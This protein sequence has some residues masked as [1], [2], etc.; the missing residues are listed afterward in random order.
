MK[1]KTFPILLGLSLAPCLHAQITYVDATTANTTRWDGV[2]FAPAADGVTGIDNNWEQRALGNSN[3]IYESNGENGAIENAPMLVT[4]ITGLQPGKEYSL[5]AYYWG[6]L[7]NGASNWRLKAAA[8]TSAIQDNGT[9]ANL[10]DDFLAT[11]PATH[12]AALNNAGGTAT[13]GTLASASTYV[14]AP[15]FIQADRTMM[16]ASLGSAVADGTGTL[17]IYIDDFESGNQPNRTW[18]DGF[19]YQILDSDNDGLPNSWEIANG[20]DPDVNDANEDPDLDDLTNIEEFQNN[21]L[22]L[23]PDTDGDG[24]DDGPEVDAGTLVNNEDSDGDFYLDGIETDR[25][26]D[27]LDINSIPSPTGGLKVDFSSQNSNGQAGVFHHEDWFTYVAPH[28]VDGITDRTE[29]WSVP[30][31]ASA[32]VSLAVAYPDTVANTVKQMIGRSNAQAAAYPGES[33][34]LVRDW[35]GIDARAASGGNGTTSDTTMTFT[36]QGLPAGTYRYRAYHHDVEFQAGRF[37]IKVTDSTRSAADLG[38]FRMSHTGMNTYHLSENPGGDP[39]ELSSTIDLIFVSN[40]TDP[41]VLTYTGRET[42]SVFTSFVVVN[43]L[44]VVSDADSDGD[45]VPNSVDLHPGTNDGTLDDDSDG[46][47]NLREYHLGTNPTLADTDGD[48]LN[49]GIETDSGTV[50]GSAD[51]GTSPFRADTDGDGANDG[52]E[53]A[54]ASNPFDP[55]VLPPTVPFKVL[56]ATLNPAT[57]EYTIQWT[58]TAGATYDIVYSDTLTDLPASWPVA[59]DNVASQGATTTHTIPLG[60]P[61]PARRFFVVIQN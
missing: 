42:A 36:F 10:A 41:V 35:I 9:P 25:Q 14:T 43:G 22:P 39:A 57:N 16:Q 61:R 28:E 6:T 54:A 52:A 23:N 13:V 55:T 31:F 45:F 4:T 17:K 24:L 3:T 46:L 40:G 20:T 11:D 44:E 53:I 7:A 26:T 34:R 37:G 1:P 33:P 51:S 49:D 5:Y 18:Y 19:G 27:P 47:T 56:T 59:A 58:S 8:S 12:F 60:A 32:S 21:G 48:G 50:A 2:T 38:F 15:T 30:A 29:T